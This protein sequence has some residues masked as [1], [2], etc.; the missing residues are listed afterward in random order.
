MITAFSASAE[1]I[2]FRTTS[3]TYKT[4]D[5]RRWS[6]WAP[7]QSSNMLITF[8]FNNDVVTI[9]SPRIQRYRIL[10]YLG[11]TTDRDGDKTLKYDFLD[12]DGDYGVMRLVERVSGKCEIYI[13]F[14]NVIWVYSV[15]RT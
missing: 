15:I 14:R 9:L 12:Q 8:D 3:Y 11:T 10:S 5:G 2:S 6:N 13:D 1:I 7:Y 4:Y